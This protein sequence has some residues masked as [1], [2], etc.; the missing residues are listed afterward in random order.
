MFGSAVKENKVISIGIIG[1]IG[2]GLW[3]SSYTD[4]GVK[5]N[6]AFDLTVICW[7]ISSSLLLFGVLKKENL[8]LRF[9]IIFS[10]VWFCIWAAIHFALLYDNPYISSGFII[11]RIIFNLQ[12][13]I[14]FVFLKPYRK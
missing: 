5:L 14:W 13:I 11:F 6:E 10:I 12:P 2:S 4:I 1:L 3:L 8:S 7:D 9:C